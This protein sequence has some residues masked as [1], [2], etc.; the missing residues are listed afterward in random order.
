MVKCSLCA[1]PRLD[2]FKNLNCKMCILSSGRYKCR[3]I[4]PQRAGHVYNRLLLNCFNL[5]RCLN[6][7]VYYF[8]KWICW[9]ILYFDMSL[10]HVGR[11]LL[12][13]TDSRVAYYS[14]AF[15]LKVLPSWYIHLVCI[16]VNCSSVFLLVTLCHREW[17][18][19]N[20]RL[21]SGCFKILYS[22]HNK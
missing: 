5:R 8:L 21:I 18:R 7:I 15:L 19:S 2:K 4:Q 12:D 9:L 17:W 13:D 3:S 20:L 14:S 22:K 11:G 6:A 10:C 1:A 16:P